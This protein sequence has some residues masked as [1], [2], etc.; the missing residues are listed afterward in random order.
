MLTCYKI[1][2]LYIIIIIIIN[3]LP[4][5]IICCCNLKDRGPGR[6]LMSRTESTED[7]EGDL[8]NEHDMG[9]SVPTEISV[10]LSKSLSES[11]SKFALKSG[12]VSLL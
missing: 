2:I 5:L 10:S 7:V 4:S 1:K 3:H 12:I 8:T 11:E 6:N 9:K